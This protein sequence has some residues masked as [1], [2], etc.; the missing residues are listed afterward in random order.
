MY[1]KVKVIEGVSPKVNNYEFFT[2][3]YLFICYLGW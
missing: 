3:F 2:N 1:I